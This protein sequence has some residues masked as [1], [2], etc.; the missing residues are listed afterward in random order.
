[1]I[2]G[3][4]AKGGIGKLQRP[5]VGLQSTITMLEGRRQNCTRNT[6]KL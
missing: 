4:G 5:R 1:M 2:T 3:G 6:V